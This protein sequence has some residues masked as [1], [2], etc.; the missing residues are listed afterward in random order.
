MRR[1]K[2]LE[3]FAKF[4]RESR[5]KGCVRSGKDHVLLWKDHILSTMAIISFTECSA[6]FSSKVL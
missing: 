6:A 2:A 5:W 1:L 4:R 3:S